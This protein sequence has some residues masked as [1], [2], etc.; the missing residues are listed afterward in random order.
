MESSQDN[1]N[2]SKDIVDEIK[3]FTQSEM[4]DNVNYLYLN[5]RRITH[6]MRWFKG[7]RDRGIR[8]DIAA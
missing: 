6:Q 8:S 7:S 1:I 3:H 5:G 2:V 4:F